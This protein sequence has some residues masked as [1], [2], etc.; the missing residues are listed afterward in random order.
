MKNPNKVQTDRFHY[1]ILMEAVTHEFF[2]VHKKPSG[3]AISFGSAKHVKVAYLSMV[4]KIEN[5]VR[6]VITTDE[7]LQRLLLEDLEMLRTNITKISEQNNNDL[8]II[9]NLF[10]FISHFLGWAYIDGKFHRTPIFYQSE[11]EQEEA[12]R[13]SP[14]ARGLPKG[15]V[16][17]YYRRRIIDQLTAKGLSHSK[18][19]LAMRLSETAIKHLAKATYIDELYEKFQS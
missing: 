5:R 10:F 17:A 1:S 4:R 18:I 16:E 12:L 2:G 9:A 15:L 8:E 11:E 14:P 3:M 13:K 6:N 7:P 19:A